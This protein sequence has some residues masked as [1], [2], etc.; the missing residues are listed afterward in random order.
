MCRSNG[1]ILP[2]KL[3]CLSCQCT[4]NSGCSYRPVLN[5]WC[6]RE[7]KLELARLARYPVEQHVLRACISGGIAGDYYHFYNGCKL[8]LVN[9]GR[10]EG[11]DDGISTTGGTPINQYDY[12]QM[13]LETLEKLGVL[14]SFHGMLFPGQKS[15]ARVMLTHLARIFRCKDVISYDFYVVNLMVLADNQVSCLLY[16]HKRVM[17]K[18]MSMIYSI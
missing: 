2:K 8:Y 4:K 18:I 12:E 15:L 9:M 6:I 7:A 5:V 16:V 10:Q 14:T 1:I 3:T 11:I 17:E 13:F